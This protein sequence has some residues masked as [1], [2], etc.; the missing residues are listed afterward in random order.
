[1]TA[2]SALEARTSFERLVEEAQRD[3][4]VVGLFLGG[5][6]G[7]GRETK[8]SDYD[9]YVIVRDGVVKA[10]R[11][12][13]GRRSSPLIEISVMSESEFRAH[14]ALDGPDAANRYD[15]AHVKALLDRNGRIQSLLEEKGRIPRNRVR[16]YV[17]SHLDAY[18]SAVYRSFKY[19]QDGDSFPAR[20]E[21]AE[22]ISLLLDAVFAIDGGRLRPYYKYLRWELE[23]FTLA[24]FPMTPTQLRATILRILTTGDSE[25][26]RKLFLAAERTARRAGYGKVFDNWA[27]HRLGLGVRRFRRHDE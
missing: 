11:R 13:Y 4:N 12:K 17:S 6:R 21:A 24:S 26:Q 23:T 16:A 25:S 22:S 15:F 10:F 1:M 27:D 2:Q 14:A 20:L 8:D 18:V 5:S 9:T 3:R 19:W 7:K